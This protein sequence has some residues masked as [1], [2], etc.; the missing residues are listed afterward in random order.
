MFQ[1]LYVAATGLD[2]FEKEMISITDNLANS[3]TVGF[4]KGRT[5]FESLYYIERTFQDELN[6]QIMMQDGVGRNMP[7]EFGTGVKIAGT[8]KDFTQGTIEITN[9]PLDLAIQGEGFFQVQLADGTVAY[10]RA[11]NFHMDNEGNLVDPNG[12]IVEPEIVIP[13]GT[14]AININRDGTI[15]VSVNNEVTSTE[16]GQI[17]LARFTNP[18]GLESIGQNLF[19]ATAA[20]GDPMIGYPIDDGYGA[21]AQYSVESSNVDIISEMM[22]MVMVQRVFDTV[23][24]A[25]QSYEAMLAALQD[26]KS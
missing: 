16:I 26:M 6:E 5:E 15:W 23:T 24:K 10:S 20:S 21:V 17:T 13:D 18:V 12:H 19:K 14:T 9:N 8:P 22:R 25:V 7:I 2:A 4:K 3:N 1:P 11:G